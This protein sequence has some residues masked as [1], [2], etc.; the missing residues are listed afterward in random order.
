[1]VGVAPFSTVAALVTDLQSIRLLAGLAI[2][3]AAIQ[4]IHM[5]SVRHEGLRI[6]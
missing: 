2:G 1:L 4:F 6:I 3:M 5:R